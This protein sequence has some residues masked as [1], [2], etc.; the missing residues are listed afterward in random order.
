MT[1]EA[2]RAG[3]RAARK[4]P[5]REGHGQKQLAYILARS[6]RNHQREIARGRTKKRYLVYLIIREKLLLGK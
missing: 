6:G 3:S 4:V 1:R 2:G 5:G